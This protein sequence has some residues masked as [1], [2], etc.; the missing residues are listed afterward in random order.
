[1]VRQYDVIMI[2][3]D[4]VLGKEKGKYRPCVIVSNHQFNRITKTVWAIP[5][6]SREKRYPTDVEIETA[7]GIIYGVVDC[8]EIRSLDIDYRPFKHKDRL[9]HSC[10]V[11]VN[12]RIK[13][14]LNL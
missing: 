4:P 6:T 3:L 12:Q 9:R 11:E 10:I 7:E 2:D 14:I 1:M 13:S 8:S 5:I